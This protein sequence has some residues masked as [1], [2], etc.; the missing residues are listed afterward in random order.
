MIV[1]INGSSVYKLDDKMIHNM[2]VL[3]SPNSKTI[4]S[5][6]VSSSSPSSWS[7]GGP[8]RRMPPHVGSPFA[9]L[10]A[11]SVDG[12]G[13]S[14]RSNKSS[15][16]YRLLLC[17]LWGKRIHNDAQP[18]RSSSKICQITTTC[19]PDE[20]LGSL[21]KSYRNM[22][23]TWTGRPASCPTHSCKP[24]AHAMNFRTTVG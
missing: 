8:L 3:H 14:S 4:S 18:Q 1:S 6:H 16:V 24:L 2:F 11:C 17:K 22:A 15:C 13:L 7:L 5:L 19:S 23:A 9:E 12:Q 21:V 10:R 20:R